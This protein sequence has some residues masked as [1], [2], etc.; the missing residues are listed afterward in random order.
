MSV[1]GTKPGKILLTAVCWCALFLF[2]AGSAAAATLEKYKEDIQH[3]KRDFAS[4]IAEETDEEERREIFAEVPELFPPGRTI[5]VDGTTVEIENEWLTAAVERYENQADVQ[6]RRLLLTAVYERLDAIELKI[7]ELEAAVARKTSKDEQ[8]RKL[9]E[10]LKREEFQKPAVEEESLIQRFLTWLE[11]LFVRNAPK[12]APPPAP[13]NFG[14]VARIM[15]I[16]LFVLVLG[17]LAFLI[18]KFA[19]FLIGKYRRRKKRER[20][21]RIILGE[22]IAAGETPDNLFGE[23]EK[24]ADEGRLRDAIRKGYIAFLFELSERRLIGLAKHKT[25]RDYLR[26]VRKERELHKKMDGLTANYERH[27]YGFEEA[28]AEDWEEFRT[29]YREALSDG[30]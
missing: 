25:N 18:Y 19:P 14:G 12:S 8:K 17:L 7:E 5:E 11:K 10:I 2:M 9:A 24:L 15:Q 6:E 20:G 23:A 27:W 4:L 3:L 30:R 21:E 26:S 13:S 28:A 29:N 22:K 16:V 1:N